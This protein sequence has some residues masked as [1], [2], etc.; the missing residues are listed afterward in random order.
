MHRVTFAVLLAACRRDAPPSTP[1]NQSAHVSAQFPAVP[2][3]RVADRT[4]FCAQI[5]DVPCPSACVAPPAPFSTTSTQFP[6]VELWA[7][8]AH[9]TDGAT[10]PEVWCSLA[11]EHEGG[12]WVLPTVTC[13]RPGMS[14]DITRMKVAPLVARAEAVLFD[15]TIERTLTSMDPGPNGERIDSTHPLVTRFVTACGVGA[16]GAPSCTPPVVVG[17]H[18]LG[19]TYVE[20]AWSLEG[21]VL[22]LDAA[23]AELELEGD[24]APE[25]GRRSLVFP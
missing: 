21:K 4:A 5:D 12:W 19:G 20:R 25:G 13:Q 14:V 11:V 8:T 18:T 22:V 16:S 6:R 24:V 3:A 7:R 2:L 1:A 9:C 10:P 17:G 23:P 15:Y